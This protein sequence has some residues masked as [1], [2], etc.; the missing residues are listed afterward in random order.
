M[1]LDTVLL[2]VIVGLE[3]FMWAYRDYQ[4]KELSTRIDLLELMRDKEDV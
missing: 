1:D 4:F 3:L 2:I